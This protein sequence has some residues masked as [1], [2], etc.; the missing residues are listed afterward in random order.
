MKKL[1]KGKTKL[2]E[3]MITPQI[4]GTNGVVFVD[5][6]EGKYLNEFDFTSLR[7]Q[8]KLLSQNDKLG[9]NVASMIGRQFALI[10]AETLKASPVVAF[11]VASGLLARAAFK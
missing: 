3:E 11:T 2:F 5:L 1:F 4:S 9:I 7:K 10:P 6:Y 8:G